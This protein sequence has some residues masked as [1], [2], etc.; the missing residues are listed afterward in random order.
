[1][2]AFF[3][4][5]ER[6]Y[7]G[8][9]QILPK[10]NDELSWNNFSLYPKIFSGHKCSVQ[11]S[12]SPLCHVISKHEIN[13]TPTKILCLD[14]RETEAPM[15]ESLWSPMSAPPFTHNQT[16]PTHKQV[17]IPSMAQIRTYA[18]HVYGWWVLVCPV[19]GFFLFF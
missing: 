4:H 19:S 18:C 10:H 5:C 12:G 8:I 9:L 16:L 3:G 6:S 1:M 13:K 7:K 15:W 14:V 17:H 2:R 11:D